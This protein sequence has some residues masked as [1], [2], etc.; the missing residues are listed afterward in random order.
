M[1]PRATPWLTLGVAASYD[2]RTGPEQASSIN[3]A[4]QRRARGPKARC[5]GRQGG[6]SEAAGCDDGDMAK[7]G[8]GGW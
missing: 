4:S 1:R 5:P 7:A 2:E 3:R 6:G 8:G